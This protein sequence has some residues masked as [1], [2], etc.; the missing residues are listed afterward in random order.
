M[1]AMGGEEGKIVVNDKK[2]LW[3]LSKWGPTEARRARMS[4]P[5]QEEEEEGETIRGS[6]VSS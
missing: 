4:W 1:Y 2:K 3:K 5:E 6:N